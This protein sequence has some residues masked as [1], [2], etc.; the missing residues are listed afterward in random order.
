[1]CGIFALINHPLSFNNSFIQEQFEKGKNRGP[2]DSKLLSFGSDIELGFHRLAING[3]NNISSQP[4]IIDNIVLICNGEIYNY[5]ELF[6]YMHVE[7]FTESDC[8][9]IIHLYKQFGIEQTLVMLDGVFSFVLYDM[10]IIDSEPSKLFVARD[11]LGVRPLYILRPNPLLVNDQNRFFGVASD[12]KML[13]EFYNNYQCKQCYTLEQ[14]TPGTYSYFEKTSKILSRWNEVS[15]NK[16]Y[17]LLS[18]SSYIGETTENYSLECSIYMIGIQH[19]L[20]NAVQKRYLNTERPIACLL[21]GGLDSSLITALVCE[22]HSKISDTPIETYSIGLQNSE[23]LKYAKQVAEYLGTNHTEIIVTE[24]EMIDAIP[25]VIEAIESYDTTTVRASIGNYLLGKYISQHSD[26]KVIFNGD[27]S[28]ELSGGYLYM[29]EAPNCLEFDNECRRLLQNISYFDVLRSDK[30]ISCHGLEP[31]TPF[32]DRSFVQYYLSIPSAIRFHTYHN[33]C[34]KYLL[35]N[36]FSIHNL[37]C[38]D[39]SLLPTEVLWRKKEAFS[40]GVSGNTRSLYT[41]LQEY[42][43][44]IQIESTNS[45]TINIPKTNEQ[46]YYRKL[47]NDF[48]PNLDNI[49]PYFWMPKYIHSTDPSARTLSIYNKQKITI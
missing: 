13:S 45:Y 4:I 43:S 44:L 26:A 3:L 10:N 32:L 11:P 48:Y 40:D 16:P 23:D 41:I 5:K 7:P 21:S 35:R 38:F 24:K 25:E 33:A 31:R 34:E 8:E 6:K 19:H 29:G 37:D 28:D 2:E 39:K 46:K 20:C 36:S 14:F 9:V 47:F 1:M 42:T 49:I 17:F 12:L 15:M 22:I 27:G 18:P 30:C